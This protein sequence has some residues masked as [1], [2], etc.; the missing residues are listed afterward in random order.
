MCECVC[1]CMC[2]WW[3]CVCVCVCVRVCVKNTWR[4]VYMFLTHMDLCNQL[5]LSNWPMLIHVFFTLS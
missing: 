3:V 5:S 1:V 2:V 4:A